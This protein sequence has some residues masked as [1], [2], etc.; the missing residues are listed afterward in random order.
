MIDTSVVTNSEEL[1]ALEP[2]WNRL[3]EQLPD[4]NPFSS[5]AWIS[6]WWQ[7][8]GN[9]RKLAVIIA[10]IDG[11]IVGIAPLYIERKTTK[12]IP[13]IRHLRLIGDQY[14]GS[15][16]LDFLIGSNRTS[17]ILSALINK[18]Q[19]LR[20]DVME[21]KPIA[22]SSRHRLPMTK[23]ISSKLYRS[24]ES[25]SPMV[26]LPASWDDFMGSLSKNKRKEIRRKEKALADLGEV[27]L[28]EIDLADSAEFEKAF[29]VLV[30]Q[31]RSRFH[32]VGI[33]G[34]FLDPDLLAFHRNALPS[35]RLNQC[36][37][38]FLL[39]LGEVPIASLYLLV[40]GDR[41]CAYQGGIDIEYSKYGP[42]SLLDVMVIRAAIN[43]PHAMIFD[44]CQGT[45]N[46]KF[47]LANCSETTERMLGFGG[48]AVGRMIGSVAT[49]LVG[50]PQ[51]VSH[52]KS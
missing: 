23:F 47:S 28:R 40:A 31:N 3:F 10:R 8:F 50:R 48:T 46:Y 17:D 49:H 20:F 9:K 35:L 30:E 45:Q 51:D 21:L 1:G 38:I 15:T 12:K 32:A 14:V 27:S 16:Y 13:G 37:K 6:A 22:V 29:E 26:S 39:M 52:G 34:G 5:F 7:Q 43:D 36:V 24:V 33:S 44:F 18:A 25:D 41:W 4:S 2:E 42:G 11:T 19:S